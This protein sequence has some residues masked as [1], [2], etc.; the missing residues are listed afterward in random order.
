LETLEAGTLRVNRVVDD[1]AIDVVCGQ[2]DEKALA[3]TYVEYEEK[4]REYT[5]SAI[6]AVLAGQQ[7]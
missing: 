2:K 6:S 5:L 4:P 3:E 1:K 7:Q